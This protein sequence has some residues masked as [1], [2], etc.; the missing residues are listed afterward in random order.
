ML[1]LSEHTDISQV[2]LTGVRSL[3]LLAML[4]EAPKTFEEIKNAFITLGLMEQGSST[5]I[6]RIDLNTLRNS[7]CKITRAG[8]KTDYRYTLL[9]HPFSL[10]IT[11]D[12]FTVIKRIYTRIKNRSGIELMLKYHE[13]FEKLASNIF[14]M[15]MKEEI[16]GLSVLRGMKIAMIKELLDD[17]SNRKTLILR[18][19]NPTAKEPSPKT[20][21]AQKVVLQNDSVY[22]YCYDF[23][24]KEQSILNIKR[25]LSIISRISGSGNVEEKTTNVKFFLKNSSI[26]GIE[27]NEQVIEN[28]A[29]GM[30]VEGRYYNDFIAIQRILSFGADCTVLEPADFRSKII[31]KLKN[32]RGVYND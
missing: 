11:K 20:V 8:S 6:I 9:S 30:V 32:M 16:L 17:C 21:L 5:D 4:I 27:E 14:D 23:G 13:L 18:Y 10:E 19:Q 25:I 3:V 15:E 24:K 28:L 26:L 31:E 2:S 29:D 22:L 12:E 7:G 1:K